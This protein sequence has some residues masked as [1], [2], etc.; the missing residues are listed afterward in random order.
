VV[1]LSRGSWLGLGLGLIVFAALAPRSRRPI[2][3]GL[4]AGFGGVAVAAAALP[5][6]RVL[7]IVVDRA[8]SLVDGR[9]G[10]YDDR[11]A[12]WREALRQIG[13]RPVLGSGPGGYPVLALRSPSRV[14]TVAPNHA[15]DLALTVLAEQG[16]LGLIA[17][18]A[19]V[20]IAAIAALRALRFYGLGSRGGGF[21]RRGAD[22]GGWS[23]G[24]PWRDGERALLAGIVAALAVVLGEGAL[25]YPLRNPVLATM[26][27]LLIG[28]LAGAVS[29][30]HV[31][32]RREQTMRPYPN[33]GQGS[34]L[35]ASRHV[36]R[37]RESVR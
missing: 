21:S 19:A 32:T 23:Y 28:L 33:I 1:S 12:I 7:S 26:V 18:V 34:I 4:L 3:A 9:R 29:G 13:E 10:P 31:P 24:A 22:V 14:T 27:W 36:R 30:R 20:T 5:R 8:A 17:L 25:D 35:V 37:V 16:M 15:H 2:A 11:P 6:S